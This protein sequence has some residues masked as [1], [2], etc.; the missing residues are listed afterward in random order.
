MYQAVF[1]LGQGDSTFDM[2]VYAL[3][4]SGLILI[5]MAI[6]GFG[7]TGGARAV[8]GIIAVLALGYAAYLAFFFTGTTYHIYP[9]V[10]VLPILAIVNAVR[11]RSG[12]KTA[13]QQSPSA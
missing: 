6:A 11:S 7:A 5:F 9:Y 1:N 2:Y 10:F 4:V 3:A 13:E 8:S 12:R